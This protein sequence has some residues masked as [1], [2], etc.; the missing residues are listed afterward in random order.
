VNGNV[1]I[2]TD[3][4]VIDGKDIR[5]CVKITATKVTIKNSK[6]TCTGTAILSLDRGFTGQRVLIEDSEISCGN[7]HGSG[8]TEA[9][10]TVRRANIHGCEHDVDVNQSVDVQD[11]WIHGIFNGDGAHAD[12]VI[13]AYGHFVNGQVINGALNVTIR[14]NRIESWDPA[15]AQGTDAIISNTGGDT[16]VTIDNNLLDG[17]A[18][19]LYC[20]RGAKGTN[21]VVTN[22]HFG[23][24]SAYG[25]TIECTDESPWS[26]N[27]WDNTGQPVS[28]S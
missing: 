18:Y 8:V 15:G 6:V 10:I 22:N 7:W 26:G 1:T 2:S 24:R 16:N 13:L 12:G 9:N 27:V 14:H 19:A 21:Y 3:G 23:R 11:S 25:P 28:V 17:G 5:G 20:E 4:T